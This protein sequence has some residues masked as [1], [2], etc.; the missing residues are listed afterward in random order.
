M[1]TKRDVLVEGGDGLTAI[2]DDL[3]SGVALS[4]ET[5]I[6]SGTSNTEIAIPLLPAGVARLESAKGE[7]IAIGGGPTGFAGNLAFDG[8][9]VT[10]ARLRIE[11]GD[12]QAP[13]FSPIALYLVL[14]G[15]PAATGLMAMRRR[16]G[17]STGGP[18]LGVVGR[19]E[20]QQGR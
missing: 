3:G 16:D 8:T 17:P 7:L 20:Q 19:A 5:E 13:L 14:P 6:A 11:F 15:L 10:G 2:F 9:D 12:V 18:A 4:A 1:Y